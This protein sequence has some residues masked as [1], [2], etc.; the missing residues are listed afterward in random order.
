LHS[1]AQKFRCVFK[2][3]HL[4]RFAPRNQNATMV[5]EK[6]LDRMRRNFAP[7]PPDPEAK[8][9]LTRKRVRHRLIK[10]ALRA[11][12]MDTSQPRER[13]TTS[14]TVSFAQEGWET[15]FGVKLH[16]RTFYE[17]LNPSS[18]SRRPRGKRKK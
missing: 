15:R 11:Y 1:V 10:K 7:D 16:E 6:T 13:R 12:L 8:Q 4:V 5:D 3:C 9:R 18:R 2:R 17:V 14:N